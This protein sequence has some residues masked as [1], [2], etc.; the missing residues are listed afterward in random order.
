[1]LD[2]PP[3]P[4]LHSQV[5][6][7]LGALARTHGSTFLPAFEK[8]VREQTVMVRVLCVFLRRLYACD[9][10]CM[11]INA[12][13]CCVQYSH[14][15]CMVSD[16]KFSVFLMDDVLEFCGPEVRVY[17]P[18]FIEV[19]VRCCTDADQ[20]SRLVFVIMF[21]CI[22]VCLNTVKTCVCESVCMHARVRSFVCMCAHL[23]A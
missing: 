9:S 21:V 3:P 16:R 10:A 19:L 22:C 15:A 12:R 13:S 14:P 8:H 20:P 17:L 4:M 2:I 23:R 6:D 18:A 1:M 11:L 7:C 5:T